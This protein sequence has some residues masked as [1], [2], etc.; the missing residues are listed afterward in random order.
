MSQGDE[1][2]LHLPVLGG[3]SLRAKEG[4]ESGREKKKERTWTL[5]VASDTVIIHPNPRP[6]LSSLVPFL[7]C[8]TLSSSFSPSPPPLSLSLVSFLHLLH[9]SESAPHRPGP[10]LTVW[11][12]SENPQRHIFRI[13]EEK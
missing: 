9:M 11:S 6:A 5:I 13:R 3:H 4:E 10:K 8:R 2:F 12:S 1:I 7:P